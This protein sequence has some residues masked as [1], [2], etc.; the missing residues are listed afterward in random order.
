MRTIELC[1]P[2]ELEAFVAHCMEANGFASANDF[3]VSLLKEQQQWD[4]LK[5]IEPELKERI[6][7]LDRGEGIPMTDADWDALHENIRAKFEAN[8]DEKCPA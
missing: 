6:E 3:I 4:W 1:L 2:E 5:R 7:S 8:E